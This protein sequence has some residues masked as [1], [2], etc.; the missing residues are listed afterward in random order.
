MYNINKPQLLSVFCI[1]EQCCFLSLAH[2]F[3]EH[4]Q[5]PTLESMDD[6]KR[7]I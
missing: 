4:R 5:D 1:Q 2:E 3:Q 6:V 7:S